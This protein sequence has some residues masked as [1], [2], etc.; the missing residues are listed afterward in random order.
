MYS[1]VSMRGKTEVAT[2]TLAERGNLNNVVTCMNATGTYVPPLIVFLRKNMQTELMDRALA[3][4]ILT[5]Y[6]SG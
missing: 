6:P 1:I 4:S 5:C 2:L 3:G